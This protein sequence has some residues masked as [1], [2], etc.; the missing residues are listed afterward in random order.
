M[1]NGFFKDRRV[2][3]LTAVAYMGSLLFGYV[4]HTPMHTQ[5]S[6]TTSRLIPCLQL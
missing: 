3:M 2:Y 4:K 5:H 1:G 6:P